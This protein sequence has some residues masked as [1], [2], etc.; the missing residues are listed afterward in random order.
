MITA[1]FDYRLGL[2]TTV[3]AC[4][5]L[6]L[7]SNVGSGVVFVSLLAGTTAVMALMRMRSRSHFYSVFIVI[8]AAYIVGVI[9]AEIG[10]FTK[11]TVFYMNIVWATANAL[12]TSLT[13][14]FL[15]PILENVFNLT[16]RFTLL[17]LTDLNK[18]ILKRINLEAPG[19]YHHSMLLGNLVD[20]VATEIGADPLKARVMAYYHDMGKI[21]KPEYYVENQEGALNP[22]E[23][24]TPQMSS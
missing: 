23:K 14:M 2:V 8:A 9:G 21:F 4:M 12:G 5:L 16:T 17:E 18:P 15:L 1:L 20:T 3:F 13:A 22:H 6:P 24:I 10:Q 19:T 7:I 11:F